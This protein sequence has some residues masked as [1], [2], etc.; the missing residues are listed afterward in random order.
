MIATIDGTNKLRLEAENEEE[1]ALLRAWY[2]CMP[3][4]FG[5]SDMD[6]P[7]LFFMQHMTGNT[8][9]AP[10]DDGEPRDDAIRH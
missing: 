2:G 7:G 1:R 4:W 8:F 10:G 6:G 5:E 9:L 3:W